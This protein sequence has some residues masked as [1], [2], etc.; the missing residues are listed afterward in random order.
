MLD[1]SRN[2]DLTQRRK[3]EKIVRPCVF[4][5]KLQAFAKDLSKFVYRQRVD[6]RSRQDSQCEPATLRTFRFDHGNSHASSR[7]KLQPLQRAVTSSGHSFRKR[8]SE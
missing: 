2:Q 3:G 4:A 6:P 8:T 5:L 1:C 7:A